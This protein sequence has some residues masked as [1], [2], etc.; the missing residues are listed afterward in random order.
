MSTVSAKNK[1]KQS[2]TT[3]TKCFTVF[4]ELRI[5]GIGDNF[6][7]GSEGIPIN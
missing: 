6:G 5:E 4:P 3:T 1:A 2:K 7:A